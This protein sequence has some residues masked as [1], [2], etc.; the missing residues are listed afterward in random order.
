MDARELHAKPFKIAGRR[1]TLGYLRLRAKR[2][3]AKGREYAQYYINVPKSLAEALLQG[4]EP[5]APGGPGVLLTV[6]ATPSPWFHALDWSQL[7]LADLPER[8]RREIEAL[9]LDKLD[10]ETI[11]IPATRDQLE[12]LGLDPD[13]PLTLEDVVRAVERRLAAG[14]PAAREASPKPAH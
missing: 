14:T 4:R 6:L 7:P 8:V 2:V 3:K 13:Q 10:Q 12:Q 11:L 5:P 1:Y 9:G